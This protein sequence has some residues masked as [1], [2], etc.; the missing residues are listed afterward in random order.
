MCITLI[1]RGNI[2]YLVINKL[3]EYTNTDN[4]A[5]QR[6]HAIKVSLGSSVSI[7]SGYGLDD[8]ATRVR[9]PTE[10][11]EFLS[12]NSTPALGPTWP[13]VKWE[14]GRFFPRG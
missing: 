11:R 4:I 14:L 7:V 2:Q 3:F 10:A 5:L 1:Y 13:P 6:D 9:S 8:R 12:Q